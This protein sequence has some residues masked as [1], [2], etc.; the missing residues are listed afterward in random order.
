M[1][2]FSPCACLATCRTDDNNTTMT[3][4]ESR[5][6]P[7]ESVADVRIVGMGE[8][9]IRLTWRPVPHA[10]R[11]KVLVSHRETENATKAC[12][13]SPNA[14][15]SAWK[16]YQFPLRD[17]PGKGAGEGEALQDAVFAAPQALLFAPA[18]GWAGLLLL[19]QTCMCACL[20]VDMVQGVVQRARAHD[21]HMRSFLV[22]SFHV[23]SFLWAVSPT[24]GRRFKILGGSA[25][26]GGEGSFPSQS[27]PTAEYWVEAA[28]PY[29]QSSLIYKTRVSAYVGWL[30]SAL[31]RASARVSA[32]VSA[33][34]VASERRR[35]HSRASGRD[36][37]PHHMSHSMTHA[38]AS[39]QTDH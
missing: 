28:V 25:H 32:C 30:V 20:D 37:I 7:K 19:L 16:A 35:A 38:M 27:E 34:L 24:C 23:R 18:A 5:P 13:A 2:R 31:L 10:D 3:Q 21:A 14:T 29:L 12:S 22:R 4:V 33:L 8:H 26:G 15:W 39:L 1:R 9:S 17:Y 36:D 6:R 11:Y